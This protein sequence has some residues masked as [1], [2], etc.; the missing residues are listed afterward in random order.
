VLSPS[1]RAALAEDL[2]RFQHD[3][4]GYVL[5]AF[6]WGVAGTELEKEPGP[7]TWQR[8]V[9]AEVGELVSKGKTNGEAIQEAVSSGHGIGKSALVSWLS[10][11]AIATHEDA[12]GVITANT[13][14]Q[15]QKKTWP[16]LAKWHRLALD[17]DLFVCTATAIHAADPGH[18]KTWRLDAVTWSEHNTEAFAGL[19]NAGKRL[20]VI[21]DEAS[22]I[23]DK[24]WEVT[25]GALTDAETEIL[26]LVFGNPTVATG[27]FRECFRKNKH[28]WNARQ[29]DSRTVEGTNKVQLDKWVQ[30]HGEDSDFVKVR[31]RGI[32]P[33]QSTKQ[34]ISE[35]DVDAA[36]GKHLRPEQ[37]NF[38]PKIL[39]CDPA[40]EGDDELVISLRQGLAFSVIRTLPKNDN[41]V[42][43]A[44]ELARLE[45]DL[46]VDAVFIDGGYGTGIKSAGTTLGR[47]HWQ[48]VWFSGAPND[49]GCLNKRAE[50][51][52]LTRDW[53]K[54]GGAIP[55]DPVLRDDL[56]GPQTCPRMDGKLQLESKDDMKARGVPSPNR[57]DSLCLSFAM[58]VVKKNRGLPVDQRQRMGTT[59]NNYNPFERMQNVRR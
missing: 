30:D 59:G 52:K 28:R 40:W 45:D 43:V 4:L 3:P 13:E 54:E 48:L 34:F 5:W 55:K 1:D 39:T 36:F 38:A 7:R 12:R 49:P 24:V 41:D 37:Y 17:R 44:N 18:E 50:M 21:F 19:H 23:A 42:W 31:V 57:A 33:A 22:G 25:E 53:L 14:T 9:L 15:L 26:W 20:I 16:E 11:W 58:P 56:I 10:R 29:I 35:A 51:W 8:E 27:R 2:G 46:Q 47:H 32:F 6:P